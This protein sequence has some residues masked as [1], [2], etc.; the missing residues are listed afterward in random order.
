MTSQKPFV[1]DG[2]WHIFAKHMADW[3]ENAHGV[4]FSIP[5]LTAR[6]K[7][8]GLQKDQQRIPSTN[9]TTA[10]FWRWSPEQV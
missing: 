1:M 3:L 9:R 6:L 8:V 5:A 7:D 10:R 2:D 4:K